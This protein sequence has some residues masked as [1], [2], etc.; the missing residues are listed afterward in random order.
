MELITD[1]YEYQYIQ[2]IGHPL[3]STVVA[4]HSDRDMH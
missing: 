1:S 4:P 3:L 2:A